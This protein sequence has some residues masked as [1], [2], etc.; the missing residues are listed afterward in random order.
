MDSPALH[1]NVEHAAPQPAQSPYRAH[2]FGGSSV[3]DA[4]RFRHVADLLETAPEPRAVVVS[5]MQGVTDALTAL[6]QSAAAGHDWQ[7]PWS[8]LRDKHLAAAYRLDGGDRHALVVWLDTEFSALSALLSRIGEDCAPTSAAL[9]AHDF[10]AVQSLGEVWSSRLLQA[11]LGGEAAG[12]AQLDARDVLV[13]HPGELGVAVDWPRTHER[14]ADWRARHPQR[15]VVVT[16]FAA[17]DSAGRCATLGRNGSDYSGAIFAVLFGA[18]DLTIWTD[19]DGVLSADPRLVPD[20]VCLPSMSYAE[21]CELA[22]F[23]AKVLHPQTM[24]PA[25]QAGLPILIRN[26]RN[27]AAPGTRIA[28]D[29]LPSASDSPVKG[30]SVV[31]D[32]PVRRM[33]ST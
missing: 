30:L 11:A 15:D 23:G 2:K 10:A 5:A 26:S 20:A 16:G 1:L 4:D 14:F 17:R 28:A 27:P 24:A 19:V 9:P 18:E 13:V 3:A 29:N 25:M 12:W 6:A 33:T 8:T 21:A 32:I 31:R 22:Y 7:D